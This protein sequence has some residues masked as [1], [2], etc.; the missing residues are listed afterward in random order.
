MRQRIGQQQ[1]PVVTQDIRIRKI[2]AEV[3]V[4]GG[5]GIFAFH[6]D[7]AE[8]GKRGTRRAEQ[9]DIF[10]V[11]PGG[12]GQHFVDD[13]AVF[14]GRIAK[15]R[16]GPVVQVLDAGVARRI[17]ILFRIGTFHVG[18]V[19]GQGVLFGVIGGKARLARALG[20]V[21][22]QIDA[23][24]VFKA[25]KGI[26]VT[27]PGH[28][29]QRHDAEGLRCNARD[30]AIP[31]QFSD[32]VAVLVDDFGVHHAAAG[33]QIGIEREFNARDLDETARH[34]RQR[35]DTMFQHLDQLCAGQG[36]QRQLVVEGQRGLDVGL[37]DPA[38]GLDH[39]A[40]TVDQLSV[41]QA[42]GNHVTGQD[43][44]FTDGRP[45]ATAILDRHDD[46]L[47]DLFRG[48]QVG[49]GG[50]VAQV[51]FLRAHPVRIAVHAGP[52]AVQE[53]IRGSED[54]GFGGDDLGLDRVGDLLDFRV[55]Q[56]LGPKVS[57]ALRVGRIGP[58]HGFI[59]GPGDDVA[60]GVE[61]DDQTADVFIAAVGVHHG[62]RGAAGVL[63]EDRVLAL[64]AVTI[65]RAVVV[66]EQPRVGTTGD[67]D[68]DVFQTGGEVLFDGDALHM[69]HQ[70]H[71][72]QA[73]I[74]GQQAVDLG[75]D[76]RGQRIQLFGRRRVVE[77]A[78]QDA[79]TPGRGNAIQRR[80]GGPDHGDL[81]AIGFQHD[82]RRHGI[83]Q[84][85]TAA[86]DLKRG[87]VHIGRKVEVRRQIGEQRTCEVL[88]QD[89]TRGRAR[90]QIG[91]N[92]GPEVEFM[93]A[94][95]DR[96]DAQLVL[97]LDVGDPG[98]AKDGRRG[99]V[100]DAGNEGIARGQRQSIVGQTVFAQVLRPQGVQHGR[101]VR[102]IQHRARGRLLI[103]DMQQ[104]QREDALFAV[105]HLDA[106][107]LDVVDGEF[108]ARARAVDVRAAPTQ[109]EIGAGGQI[110]QHHRDGLG[111]K[112]VGVGLGGRGERTQRDPG[113]AIQR[114]GK[115]KGIAARGVVVHQQIKAGDHIRQRLVTRIQVQH[116]RAGR[117][118]RPRRLDHQR[119]A[120]FAATVQR[121]KPAGGD[122]ARGLAARQVVFGAKAGD[123][124]LIQVQLTVDRII[125]KPIPKKIVEIV[126]I[127]RA[128]HVSAHPV[129]ANRA[130]IA[131]HIGSHE[132]PTS[133]LCRAR[134]RR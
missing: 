97:D 104:F 56:A 53:D 7:K 39:V 72:V 9:F 34:R 29:V 25:G 124:P 68:V 51:G 107:D 76:L 94:K 26:A 74:G 87:Q 90:D 24:G 115:I 18:Q 45:D 86:C 117:E 35:A 67:D 15:D 10:A 40:L 132:A 8:P 41:R 133:D 43:H 14:D 59:V 98:A 99:V 79:H 32:L 42:G 102:R 103:R 5:G 122:I 113:G 65:A 121:V 123:R 1:E 131:R 62:G 60:L 101:E 49:V 84:R 114:I 55:D 106:S 31:H 64:I 54:V 3:D 13:D 61:V 17:L 11:R 120:V 130:G 105:D 12:R 4:T 38:L 47:V 88:A 36:Q 111:D 19:F 112:A 109:L 20:P 85:I 2:V 129:D 75:L 27:A 118:I 77:I 92:L 63:D 22:D 21:D 134:G 95:R 46:S 96:L 69:R 23:V 16:V 73:G 71:L 33:G 57:H 110:R 91:Q 37:A 81:F 50:Q 125:G 82:R 127:N 126:R 89:R 116:Q 78:G 128:T 119:I 93:V 6:R 48:G 100:E 52:V 70:H 58:G 108:V 66:V 30:N 83:G 28:E 80:G 44:G